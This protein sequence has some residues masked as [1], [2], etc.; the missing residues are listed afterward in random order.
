MVAHRRR[1]AQ[2]QNRDLQAADCLG[3]DAWPSG[4][5]AARA[6]GARPRLDARCVLHVGSAVGAGGSRARDGEELAGSSP[7][8][9]RAISLQ[10]RSPRRTSTTL[11]RGSLHLD[12]ADCVVVEDSRN[13]LLAATAAGMPCIITQNDLTEGEDFTEAAL[14]L[15]KPGRSRRRT[16]D[17][18]QTARRRRRPACSRSTILKRSGRANSVA[19]SRSRE[20]RPRRGIEVTELFVRTIAE[21]AIANEKYFADLDGVVGDGDFGIS[22]ANGFNN[23]GRMERARSIDPGQRLKGVSMVIAS[24]VGGVSGASGARLFSAPALS[25]ATSRN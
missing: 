15:S 17:G 21:T 11:R 10:R 9:S 4:R 24:R 1:L 23:A 25:R 5:E 20:R 19:G 13:G 16:V 2:A 8:S 14:V 3:R 22:L 7:A 6:G 18:R 12:P